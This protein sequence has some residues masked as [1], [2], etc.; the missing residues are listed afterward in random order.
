[1]GVA[2][3]AVALYAVALMLRHQAELVSA[4]LE[5]D[6]MWKTVVETVLAEDLASVRLLLAAAQQQEPW[7]M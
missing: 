3:Y 5:Q 4:E 2:L 6:L 7:Q 1:M